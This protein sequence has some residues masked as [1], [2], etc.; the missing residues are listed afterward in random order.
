MMSPLT[1]TWSTVLFD[2]DGTLVHS[3][4]V[5]LEGLAHVHESL[6]LPV[7]SESDLLDWIGPPLYDSLRERAMLSDSE[8][9]HARQL[10]R[11]YT[12][13]AERHVALFPGVFGVLE[14]L[15]AAGV[16]IGLATSKPER[17]ALGILDSLGIASLFT[18]SVGAD[19]AL[20]RISKAD[21]VGEAL[22]RL[23]A[24]GVDIEAPV[25]VGD[26]GVD[27]DGAAAHAVP[28]ILVEWGYGNPSEAADALAI[29]ASAD[30]LR[31]LLLGA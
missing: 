18:V 23:A 31:S 1:R 15:V 20:G 13:G 16:P 30:Q 21:V 8:A 19:E 28:T 26:R 25:M 2:L 17:T 11:D 29:V 24:H 10:Y 4:P 12:E 22:L 6:G 27:V 9:L 7:P 3:A 5:I 14:Q